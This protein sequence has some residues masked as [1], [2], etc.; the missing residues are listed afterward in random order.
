MWS[1]NTLFS[2]LPFLVC[3]K[4]VIPCLIHFNACIVFRNLSNPYRWYTH[5]L[6]RP[7]NVHILEALQDCRADIA[8]SSDFL[9]KPEI[10]IFIWNSPI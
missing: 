9:R 3:K 6:G 1:Y 5:I 4:K 2:N 7:K 10:Q 8:R